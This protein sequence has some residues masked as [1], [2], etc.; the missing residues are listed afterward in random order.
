MHAHPAAASFVAWALLACGGEPAGTAAEGSKPE[1][2]SGPAFEVVADLRQTMLWILEPAADEIW[3]SAGFVIT[4]EGERDLSPTTDEGWERVRGSAALVAETGNLL[5][6][7][8]RSLGADWDDYAKA[9]IASSRDV[10]AAAE[11]RDAV[12]LFDTG[13]ELY[14][15]CRGCHTPYMVPIAQA[16]NAE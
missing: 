15:T 9:M 13:G 1:P 5:M 10:M 14:Q 6:M 8:G 11:A 2:P 7:P 12:A 3:D 16:R 4:V